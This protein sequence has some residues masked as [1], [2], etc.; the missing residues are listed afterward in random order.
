MTTTEFIKK[1]HICVHWSSSSVFVADFQSQQMLLTC[2]NSCSSTE[3]LVFS[4]D[5]IIGCSSFF[6]VVE[7]LMIL[8]CLV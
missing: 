1:T 4:C 7:S 3:V 5:G 2:G 8:T 6:Q